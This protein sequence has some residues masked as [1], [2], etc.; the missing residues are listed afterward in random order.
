MAIFLGLLSG[1]G[2]ASAIIAVRIAIDRTAISNEAGV[3]YTLFIAGITG[4]IIA[5][6][7]GVNFDFPFST[8]R[9]LIIIGIIA[10]GLTQLSYFIAIRTIGPSRS[11]MFLGIAPIWAVL[12]AYLFTSGKI[13]LAIILGS[14]IVFAAGFLLVNES[15]K[16]RLKIIGVIAGLYT[17]LGFAARDVVSDELVASQ[18]LNSAF[19]AGILWLAGVP[20]VLLYIGYQ[21]LTRAPQQKNPTATKS[22]FKFSSLGYIA[23]PGVIQGASL[24]S[25]LQAFKIGR[26]EIVAPISNS[27]ATVSTVVLASIFL[28]SKEWSS[29][30]IISMFLIT[31]GA[32]LVG[33]FG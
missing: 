15:F 7:T 2:W 16:E 23:I 25:M 14:L 10:P 30:V 1:I 17:G 21:K 3:F 4:L 24:A 12:G 19:S 6:I 9:N 29:K 27:I 11:G 13:N 22:S 26:V 28:G 32:V 20:I 5:F 18:N 31:I 33:I 8:V